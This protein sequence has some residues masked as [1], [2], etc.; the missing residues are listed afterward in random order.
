MEW[1]YFSNRGEQPN[2]SFHPLRLIISEQ[3]KWFSF[4]CIFRFHYTMKKQFLLTVISLLSLILCF[5]LPKNREWFANRIV[6]YWNDFSH[7][8]K[9]LGI[10]HRKIKRWGN[11]YVLSQQISTFFKNRGDLKSLILIPPSAYFKDRN[12]DYHVPEP[13]VFYYYTRLKTVW[14]NS[15]QALKAN[16]MV[17]ASNGQLNFISVTDKKILN[18]SM[19]VFKKY[20]VNL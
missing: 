3:F 18:D 12:L 10:E 15:G 16:W 13:A 19:Q 20:Q 2:K 4:V 11:D 9:D 7:Q 6:V 1:F 8:K 17:T 14:I 5:L